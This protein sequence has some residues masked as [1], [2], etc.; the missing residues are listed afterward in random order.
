MFC[1]ACGHHLPNESRFCPGC[2]VA[3]GPAGP[4][5]PS[6]IVSPTGAPLSAVTDFLQEVAS[7]SMRDIAGVDRARALEIIGSPVFPPAEEGPRTV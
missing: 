1:T 6:G 4:A 2:G 7:V 3:A 5:H